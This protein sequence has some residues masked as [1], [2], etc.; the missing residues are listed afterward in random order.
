MLDFQ[1]IQD[2]IARLEKEPTNLPNCKALASL[3]IVRDHIA[4]QSENISH[5]SVSEPHLEILPNYRDY[6]S[7]KEHLQKK[8]ITKQEALPCIKG[9]CSDLKEFAKMLVAN[10]DSEDERAELR[11]TF[12]EIGALL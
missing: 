5:Q 3:Y 1:D 7:K 10:S 4:S 11:K 12:K 6:C 9:I 2:T 8:I